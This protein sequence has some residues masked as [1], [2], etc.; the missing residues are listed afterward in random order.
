MKSQN[1][2]EPNLE[3]NGIN[4]EPIFPLQYIWQNLPLCKG[5]IL[6]K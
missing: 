5:N 1:P 3:P 6:M 2:L 4:P